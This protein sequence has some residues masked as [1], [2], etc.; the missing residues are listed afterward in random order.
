[1]T[2]R[3]TITVRGRHLPVAAAAI[4]VLQYDA[5]AY[6]QPVDSPPVRRN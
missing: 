3:I 2:G 4:T 6:R 5:N 1:M